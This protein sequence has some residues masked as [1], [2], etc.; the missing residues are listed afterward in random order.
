MLALLAL[1]NSKSCDGQF[2]MFY[3]SGDENKKIN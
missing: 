3:L 2:L 1:A